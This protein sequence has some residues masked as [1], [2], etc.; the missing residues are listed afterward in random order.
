MFWWTSG[1]IGPEPENDMAAQ[2]I[3]LDPK[4]LLPDS[5]VQM[6]RQIYFQRR[7]LQATEQQSGSGSGSVQVRQLIP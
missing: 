1:P 7:E 4:A 2:I 6:K 3:R 5:Y